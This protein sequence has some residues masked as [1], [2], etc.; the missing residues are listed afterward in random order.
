MNP[1]S[2]KDQGSKTSQFL[3][4]LID[5]LDLS[6]KRRLKCQLLVLT[7]PEIQWKINSFTKFKED[8][9][10]SSAQ[11]K[12][13]SKKEKKRNYQAQGPTI[14]P[15]AIP[16]NKCHRYSSPNLIEDLSEIQMFL[17]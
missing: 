7:N 8:I 14:I 1:I 4:R 16:R 6:I 15:K 11:L 17:Q 2:R 3:L 9:E 13:G 5:S 10:A 12:E